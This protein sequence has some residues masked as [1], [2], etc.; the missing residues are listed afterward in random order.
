[1]FRVFQIIQG[2]DLVKDKFAFDMTREEMV[3]LIMQ[4]MN[5]A[6]ISMIRGLDKNKEILRM[7]DEYYEHKN[8]TTDLEN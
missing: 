6:N 5:A 4:I 8:K 1:M 2:I 3:K 7:I